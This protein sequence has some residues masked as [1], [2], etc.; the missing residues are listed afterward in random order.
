M[1]SMIIVM[2]LL[3][4]AIASP[5]AQN[6]TSAAAPTVLAPNPPPEPSNPAVKTTQGN[7]P[8]APVTGANSFTEAQAKLRIEARGYRDVSALQKDERGIWRGRALKDS[9]LVGV[10][11]DYLTA[12][13][14]SSAPRN[15]LCLRTMRF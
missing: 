15:G 13:P 14:I 4:F 9:R 2:A 8:G 12:R 6:T 1:R 3:S 7:N 11:L 10:T 5:F